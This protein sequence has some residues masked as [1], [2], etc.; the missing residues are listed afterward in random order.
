M[1]LPK[2]FNNPIVIGLLIYAVIITISFFVCSFGDTSR[3]N[4]EELYINSV[5]ILSDLINV[6][7]IK[8]CDP[9]QQT[10]RMHQK[11]SSKNKYQPW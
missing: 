7:L 3:V 10:Q 11:R 2:I 9:L 5:N 4:L 1:T 6:Q 8:R